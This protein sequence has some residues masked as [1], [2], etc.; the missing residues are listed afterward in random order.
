MDAWNKQQSQSDKH[1]C[2]QQSRC[3]NALR[4]VCS[5]FQVRSGDAR[6][7]DVPR[8]LGQRSDVVQKLGTATC[9]N[10]QSQEFSTLRE[11]MRR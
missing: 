11:T 2:V 3:L 4:S 1:R 8:S 5:A 7:L 10:R 9:H 6:L